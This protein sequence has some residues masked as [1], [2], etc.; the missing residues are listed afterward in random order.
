MYGFI[1]DICTILYRYSLLS[2]IND[3]IIDPSSLPT[4]YTW[5]RSIKMLVYTTDVQEWTRRIWASDDFERFRKLHGTVQPSIVYNVCKYSPSRT[6][7][8]TIARAWCRKGNEAPSVCTLFAHICSDNLTHVISECP[9]T[10][11]YRQTFLSDIST[12]SACPIQAITSLD[13]ESFTL[14]MLGAPVL[15]MLDGRDTISFLRRSFRLVYN[16]LQKY[17]GRTRD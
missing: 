3:A 4:K 11:C 6:T 1:P 17:D 10:K 5:K 16:C 9:L 14:C 2:F 13:N 8:H 15:Q 12:C 7:M